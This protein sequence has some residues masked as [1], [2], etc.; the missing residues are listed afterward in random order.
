MFTESTRGVRRC[1][2]IFSVMQGPSNNIANPLE[3]ILPEWSQVTLLA[4]QWLLVSIFGAWLALSLMVWSRR[5]SL[6]LRA[7]EDAKSQN[8]GTPSYREGMDT[9]KEQVL[10]RGDAYDAKRAKSQALGT[11]TQSAQ[12]A[13][14]DWSRWISFARIGTLVVASLNLGITILAALAAGGE[15]N[16]MVESISVSDRW[17]AVLNKYWIG[18]AAAGVIILLEIGRWLSRRRPTAQNPTA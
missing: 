17:E 16:E 2:R 4:S 3:A 8:L 18:I 7:L 1:A 14:A 5:R 11:E 12:G 13:D 15:V 10:E 9:R 6:G